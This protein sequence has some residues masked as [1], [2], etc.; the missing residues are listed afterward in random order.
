MSP[1][2]GMQIIRVDA[3]NLSH[4]TTPDLAGVLRAI[5]QKKQMVLELSESDRL[6]Q[7]IAEHREVYEVGDRVVVEG[8]ECK[9]TKGR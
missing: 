4:F 6:M 9:G 8:F 7:N 3:V 1:K 5:A 2:V